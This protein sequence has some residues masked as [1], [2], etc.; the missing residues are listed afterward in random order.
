MAKINKK[1]KVEKFRKNWLKNGTCGSSTCVGCQS[2]IKFKFKI[3]GSF[4]LPA[5]WNADAAEQILTLSLDKGLYLLAEGRTRDT[6]T[7]TAYVFEDKA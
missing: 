5:F 6:I 2:P 3:E 7:Y 4:E 1:A